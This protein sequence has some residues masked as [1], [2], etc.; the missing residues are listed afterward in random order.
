MPIAAQI[1]AFGLQVAR[2]TVRPFNGL[3]RVIKRGFAPKF[4]RVRD[5][6]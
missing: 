2:A 3:Y 4:Q 1:F 5:T 6:S